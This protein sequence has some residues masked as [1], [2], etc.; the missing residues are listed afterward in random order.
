MSAVA[1]SLSFVQQAALVLLR[2][3]IGWHLAYEGYYKLLYPAWSR[4]G[5]PLEQCSSLGY[6]RGATGPL[7]SLFHWMARPEWV[8][9]IDVAVAVALL[10]AG[11]MLLLGLFTQAGCLL[12]AGLLCV[13]YVSAIPVD[14]LPQP[15]SEGTYLIVNKN[16][17]EAI[18]VS[19]VFAFRTGR[20]AGLDL[21]RLRARAAAVA[22]QTAV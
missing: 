5:A 7:A 20:F 8:P 11:I 12:A 2:T 17:I 14:G 13:F 16:L 19:V 18:A 4:T 9:Y 15:R 22:R 3:A 10:G 1:P 6:I 21:I